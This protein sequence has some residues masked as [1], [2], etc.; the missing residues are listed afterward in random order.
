MSEASAHIP[1]CAKCSARAILYQPYSGM[2]LCARHFV[3]DVERKVKRRL[4]KSRAIESGDRIAIAL[5]GGKDS[6][7]VLIMLSKL[8][9]RRR[10]VE[11]V[12][13]AVDEGISGYRTHTLDVARRIARERDVPLEVVSFENEYGSTLDELVKEGRSA[14]TYCGVLRKRLLNITA[15]RLGATKL[16]TGHNLDDEAQSVLLNYLKGD[17]ERLC[18]MRPIRYKEGLIP[19]IKPLSDVPERE[20]ALYVYLHGIELEGPTCPYAEHS[21]RFTLKHMLNELEY[22]HPGTKYAL[23]RGYERLMELVPREPFE[24]VRCSACGE[25]SVGRM[26]KAC[27]LLSHVVGSD[28]L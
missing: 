28:T 2:H 24:L 17:V 14:C 8:I 18:R 1:S 19:R 13:I 21:Y 3:L 5:S 7:S 23:L 9:E 22:E 16:A 6:S 15:R 4:R 25:P 12:A 11:L 27:E 20:T 10:D 26:C